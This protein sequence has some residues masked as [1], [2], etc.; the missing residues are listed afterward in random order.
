MIKFDRELNAEK[1]ILRYLYP[2]TN[3]FR[4]TTFN[5]CHITWSIIGFAN[6]IDTKRENRKLNK[7]TEILLKFY[8]G[9][10]IS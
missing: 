5:S 3:S 4:T 10:I 8:C 6:K 9:N 7:K 2:E 1:K